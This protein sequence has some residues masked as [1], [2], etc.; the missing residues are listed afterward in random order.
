MG[1]QP[2]TDPQKV[3]GRQGKTSF[4]WDLPPHNDSS[5]KWR[6][7]SLGSNM[8]KDV[9]H[10]ILLVTRRDDNR[11]PGGGV[12]AQDIRGAVCL[13][14]CVEAIEEPGKCTTEMWRLCHEDAN[15]HGGSNQAVVGYVRPAFYQTVAEK[16]QKEACGRM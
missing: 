6:E 4:T 3:I 12:L 13:Y 15:M 10:V 7:F 16:A 8:L 11:K 1:V 14:P 9:K 2:S 5:G